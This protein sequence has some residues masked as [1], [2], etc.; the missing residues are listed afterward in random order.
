MVIAAHPVYKGCLRKALLFGVP[1]L[2]CMAG[3]GF[4]SILG[5][6]VSYWF[7]LFIPVF[8]VVARVMNTNDDCIFELIVL[9]MIVNF[10]ILKSKLANFTSTNLSIVSSE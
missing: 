3:L 5:F 8:L 9:N 2:P 10:K 6:V 4:F 7:F 1:L